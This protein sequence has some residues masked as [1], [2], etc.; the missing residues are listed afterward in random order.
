[1]EPQY[2]LLLLN[3]FSPPEIQSTTLNIS[4]V[5]ISFKTELKQTVVSLGGTLYS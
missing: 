4:V 3:Q 2:Q 1:M 5:R